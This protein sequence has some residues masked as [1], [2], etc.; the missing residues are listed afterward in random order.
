MANASAVFVCIAICRWHKCICYWQKS[1]EP[2]GIYEFKKLIEWMH[3]NKLSLTLTKTKDMLFTLRKK[4]KIRGLYFYWPRTYRKSSAFQIIRCDHW[5]KTIMGRSYPTHK[6]RKFPTKGLVILC[7]T[8][9]ILI[10][11]TLLTL[12]Y[13]FI[14]TYM[15]YCIVIWGSTCRECFDVYSRIK[16]ACCSHYKISSDS[17]RISANV[18]ILGITI[19]IW[20]MYIQNYIVYVYICTKWGRRLC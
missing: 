6:K 20:N 11:P 10:L 7:K 18:S 13:S 17:I 12:Y 1:I 3:V 16:E 14:Y 5:L 4:A 8:K 2:H 9:I 15:L 19:C